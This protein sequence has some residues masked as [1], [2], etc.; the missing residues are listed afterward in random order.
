M[1]RYLRFSNI[2]VA[3]QQERETEW[4]VVMKEFF[5][6]MARKDVL[7]DILQPLNPHS[8]NIAHVKKT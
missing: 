3:I 5:L 1:D 4:F 6:L 8:C 2:Y 7:I